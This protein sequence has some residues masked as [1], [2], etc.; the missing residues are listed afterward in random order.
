MRVNALCQCGCGQEVS[1][2]GRMYFSRDCANKTL[3]N[4]MVAA[5]V[6][7]T[8][9]GRKSGRKPIALPRG[10]H[11][12]VIATISEKVREKYGEGRMAKH[13]RERTKGKR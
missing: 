4:R 9:P 1:K 5:Q 13:N 10:T 7:I 3:K 2:Y 11:Q 6:S 8:K 12:E